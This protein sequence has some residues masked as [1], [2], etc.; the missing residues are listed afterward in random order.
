MSSACESQPQTEPGVDVESPG[1]VIYVLDPSGRAAVDLATEIP[2]STERLTANYEQAPKGLF[3]RDLLDP[4][5]DA[6]PSV[7]STRSCEGGP[8]TGL[9]RVPRVLVA[10][11]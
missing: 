4:D 9:L 8:S 11:G 1:V 2:H 5:V 6:Y 10:R 3:C 7:S